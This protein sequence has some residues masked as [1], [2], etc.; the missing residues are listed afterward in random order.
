MTCKRSRS[1]RSQRSFYRNYIC[2]TDSKSRK[3]REKLNEF[4]QQEFEQ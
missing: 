2:Y 1:Y 3:R 4:R